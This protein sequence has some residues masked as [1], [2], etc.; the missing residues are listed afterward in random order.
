MINILKRITNS[1]HYNSKLA[2]YILPQT[3]ITATHFIQIHQVLILRLI[4]FA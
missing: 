4:F 1:Y 2:K 3:K